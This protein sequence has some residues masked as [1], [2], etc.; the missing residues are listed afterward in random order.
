MARYVTWFAELSR[1]DLAQAGGKGAKLGD[2]T[3]AGLPVPP[4]FVR[5]LV[6]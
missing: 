4:G 3:R 2:M 1:A 6:D 5:R